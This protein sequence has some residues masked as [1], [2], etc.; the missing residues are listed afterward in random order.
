REALRSARHLARVAFPLAD[1]DVLVWRAV[2]S[3]VRPVRHLHAGVRPVRR[4]A[5]PRRRSAVV[6]LSHCPR[7]DGTQP[8]EDDVR[9]RTRLFVAERHQEM[10]RWGP[11][12]YALLCLIWGS[13][14]LVIKIGYGSLGP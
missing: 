14:W 9:D 12:L 2:G 8:A 3:A 6:Y 7:V 10:E 4:V 5:A 11:A 1:P 13:T